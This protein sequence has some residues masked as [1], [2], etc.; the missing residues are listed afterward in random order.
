MP[1]SKV[2]IGV[3]I[4]VILAV[5]LAAGAMLL[6]PGTSTTTPGSTNTSTSSNSQSSTQGSSQSSTQSSTGTGIL[7]QSGTMNIYLTDAP[8]ASPQ[9]SYLLINVSSVVL[10]YTGNVSTSPPTNQW[11][12]N[13]PA[14]S[15]TNVNITSL[16]NSSALLGATKVPAGN[17]SMITFEISGARAYFTDGNSTQLK[18]V[19][20]GKLMV[21]KNFTV[22]AN[23]QSDLTVDITPNSIHLSHGST[24]VLTPVVHVTVVQKGQSGTTTVSATV[25]FT[26]TSTTTQT[27]NTTSSTSQS[28]SSTTSTTSQTSSSTTTSSSTS[29]SS[30]TSETSSTTTTSTT[31][32]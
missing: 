30:T 17:V 8:P 12:F 22:N 11:V 7:G 32:S 1:N 13:V 31:T 29:T 20:N 5:G 28:S 21:P 27:S 9:F 16:V 3:V 24:P 26:E 2:I 23:G 14:S 19:A 4:A 25:S 6:A 18:V 15:G 10:S